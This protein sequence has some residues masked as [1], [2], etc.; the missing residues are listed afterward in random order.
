LCVTSKNNVQTKVVA[1]NND[2]F[3]ARMVA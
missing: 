1:N 2:N 3:A